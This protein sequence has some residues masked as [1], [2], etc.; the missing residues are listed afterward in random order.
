MEFLGWRH[1][2]LNQQP[3]TALMA[4]IANGAAVIPD[5][6][7]IPRLDRR[8]RGDFFVVDLGAIAGAAIF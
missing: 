7:A 1:R 5:T 4:V 8:S 6:D 3:H 2:R